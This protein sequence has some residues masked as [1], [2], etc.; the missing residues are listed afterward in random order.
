MFGINSHRVV[1]AAAFA[2]VS[3]GAL[4]SAQAGYTTVKTVANE[5]SHEQILEHMYGGNFSKS[6]VNFSNGTI[7]AKRIDDS[8]PGPDG[9]LDATKGQPGDAADQVWK[10]GKFVAT[11][12][13]RYAA[14]TQSF[15]FLLGETGNTYTN[16]F[17]VSGTGFNVTGGTVGEIDLLGETFRWGRDGTNGKHSSLNSDNLDGLDHLATYKIDGLEDG[18]TTW[19]LCWE[20]LNKRSKDNVHGYK[21]DSD[22]NDLVVEVKATA[23]PIPAAALPALGMLAGLGAIK[24]ARRKRMANVA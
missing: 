18:K 3:V 19:L 12:E 6:G 4:A 13:A 10:N 16:L 15:G 7:S 22:F 1:K 24:A 5:A 8:I 17:N 14:Y 9:I 11:A 23:I 20:D 2:A 21:L